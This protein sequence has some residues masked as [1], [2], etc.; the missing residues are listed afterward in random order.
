MLLRVSAVESTPIYVGAFAALNF[1][2]V[3]IA[4]RTIRIAFHS[5]REVASACKHLSTLL[6]HLSSMFPSSRSEQRSQKECLDNSACQRTR[7]VQVIMQTQCQVQKTKHAL[8]EIEE[9]FI[10]QTACAN[11]LVSFVCSLRAVYCLSM[12]F[13]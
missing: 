3:R 6:D 8:N 10:L 11:C 13:F 12:Q 2:C 7:L 5:I 1:L 9:L 4:F